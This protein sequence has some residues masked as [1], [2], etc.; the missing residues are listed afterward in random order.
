[1][2]AYSILG[3]KQSA[4]QAEIDAAFRS[5]MDKYS[6]E[7]Y[8]ESPLA[9]LAA[10]K[11]R[12]LENA[13]DTIIKERA[14]AGTA[15]TSSQSGPSYTDSTGTHSDPV[16]AEIRQKIEYGDLNNAARLLQGISIRDAQWHYLSGCVALRRGL[17]N[18]AF[19]HFR[20]AT[21]KEPSNQEYRNAYMRMQQQSSSYRNAGPDMQQAQCWNCCSNLIIADCCCECL[22]GDLIS[23]C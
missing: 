1:M 3:I 6:E 7:K 15:N 13:Y 21:D 9:D 8:A 16:Y 14:K 2:D 4:T 19:H 22:G 18:E 23:C 5:L 17:Y 10:D 11:R 12:E 20:T